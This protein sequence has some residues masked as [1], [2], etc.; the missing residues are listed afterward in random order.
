[1]A[2]ELPYADDL[3]FMSERM[4]GLRNMFTKWKEAFESKNMKVNL[5]KTKMMVS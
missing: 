4:K 3:V 2:T 1:M 5:R